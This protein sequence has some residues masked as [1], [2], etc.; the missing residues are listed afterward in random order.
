VTSESGG[1]RARLGRVQGH[2]AAILR[3]MIRWLEMQK[4]FAKVFQ[5]HVSAK[6]FFYE[7]SVGK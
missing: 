6:K 7:G 3:M 5:K 1:K 4:N 2:F